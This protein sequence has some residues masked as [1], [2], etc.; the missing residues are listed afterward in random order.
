MDMSME[1]S[2]EGSSTFSSEEKG[3]AFYHYSLKK[4]KFTLKRK[5]N[6]DN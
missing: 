3:I 1:S 5:T 2:M 6:A 4:I